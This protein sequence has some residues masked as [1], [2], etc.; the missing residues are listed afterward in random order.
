MPNCFLDLTIEGVPLGRIIVQLRSDIVP[1]TCG[2][3]VI[4]KL[5]N[6]TA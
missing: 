2:K 5:L 6:R 1:K 4:L 3:W